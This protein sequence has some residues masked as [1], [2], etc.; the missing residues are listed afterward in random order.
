M[1]RQQHSTRRARP[2]SPSPP[3]PLSPSRIAIL[4]I[5]SVALVAG[6]LAAQ[7]SARSTYR[8]G[9][10][11]LIEIKVFEV[12]DLNVELRVEGDGIVRLP[13]LGE[14][15]VEGLTTAQVA[16]QLRAI[17]E[18]K[19]IQRASVTVDIRE[20]RSRPISV[21]GA[22]PRPGPLTVSGRW[23]L[24][25]A[26]AAAGGLA[27]DHGDTIFVLRRSDN[28]LVDQ[29]AINVEDL[30]VHAKLDVNIP[31]FTGDLINVPATIEVTVF[32]LGEVK[33][34]GAL[35]FK[36]TQ[37]L[38]LLAAIARAGGL[39]DRASKTIVIRRH[40]R[41]GEDTEIEANFKNIMSGKE[42][43]VELE[44]DDVVLV[45]ESFF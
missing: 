28:G 4:A 45:K 33:R 7:Q 24:L 18:E 16:D 36:S 29:V 12:P 22:V 9:P 17:L 20:Y 44:R 1:T 42:P 25:E 11:D 38:T 6:S 2:F 26:L 19:Y 31:V 43:D 35:T 32:C 39:T 10:K 5:L 15:R 13:L 27:D 30:M 37:R 41:S 40:D 34:P 21:I 8:I 23:T 14:L 3:L